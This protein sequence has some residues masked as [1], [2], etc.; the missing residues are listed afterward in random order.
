MPHVRRGASGHAGRTYLAVSCG[1]C[2]GE[3]AKERDH[4]AV[5]M[6]FDEIKGLAQGQRAKAREKQVT[7]RF[8]GTTVTVR[9]QYRTWP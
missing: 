1:V 8:G 2:I 9:P 3:A 5:L 6:P 7:P 4:E